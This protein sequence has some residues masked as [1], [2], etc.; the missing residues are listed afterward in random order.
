MNGREFLVAAKGLL[1]TATEATDRSAVSRAYYAAFHV[2]RRLLEDLGFTVPRTERGHAHVWLRLPN[3]GQ[4]VRRRSRWPA[5][6]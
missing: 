2:G 4:G 5:G 3:C 6:S 1:L